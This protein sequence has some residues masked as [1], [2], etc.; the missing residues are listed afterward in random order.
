MQGS[1]VVR[2]CKQHLFMLSDLVG[3]VRDGREHVSS[4]D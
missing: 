4:S 2:L 3:K 1:F